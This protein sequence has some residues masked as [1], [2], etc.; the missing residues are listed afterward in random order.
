MPSSQH[1]SFPIFR[2]Q[3]RVRPGMIGPIATAC[4]VRCV[5]NLAA[6]PD[7][8]MVHV[9]RQQGA[10]SSSLLHKKCAEEPGTCCQEI[11][12]FSGVQSPAWLDSKLFPVIF[13]LCSK[14]IYA[15]AQ[16][17]PRWLWEDKHATSGAVFVRALGL[18]CEEHALA[19]WYELGGS[20]PKSPSLP[21]TGCSSRDSWSVASPR[22]AHHTLHQQKKAPPADT[23]ISCS[24]YLPVNKIHRACY[25]TARPLFA[26]GGAPAPKSCPCWRG[27]RC[28]GGVSPLFQPA[29]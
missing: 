29:G 22:N 25:P 4:A 6:R 1:A 27:G 23:L 5:R 11:F 10:N 13:F 18:H 19:G 20:Q 16:D 15:H 24:G 28:P 8:A 7:L 21:S 12:I 3:R 26:W 2:R 9:C 14:C 17:A